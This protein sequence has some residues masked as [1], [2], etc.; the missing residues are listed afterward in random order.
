VTGDSSRTVWLQQA[1]SYLRQADPVLARLIGER[2]DFDPRAWMIQLPP[3]NLYG[4]LLFQV[5]G[6]QLSVDEYCYPLEDAWAR[7]AYGVPSGVNNILIINKAI[8]VG[9]VT[10]IIVNEHLGF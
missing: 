1:E 6:Q 3:M 10:A 2:P 5:T 9:R 7:W 4:A 8:T